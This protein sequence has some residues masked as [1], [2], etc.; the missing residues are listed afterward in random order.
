MFNS[1]FLKD[2]YDYKMEMSTF[3]SYLSIIIRSGIMHESNK[4]LLSTSYVLGYH[5]RGKEQNKWK[6]LTSMTYTLM[7]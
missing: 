2:E 1:W 7:Q 3:V 5:C 6:S 4:N